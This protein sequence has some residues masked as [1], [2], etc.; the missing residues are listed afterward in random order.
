MKIQRIEQAYSLYKDIYT[1]LV[2]NHTNSVCRAI[3]VH[4]CTHSTI[5]SQTCLYII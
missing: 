5:T 1:K 3:K 2:Y 4:L